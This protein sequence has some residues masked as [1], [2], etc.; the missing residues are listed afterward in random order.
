MRHDHAR[1][2][3]EFADLLR[4]LPDAQHAWHDVK[5]LP[6]TV[7]P[8]AN[9]LFDDPVAATRHVGAHGQAV[10]GRRGDH[11]DLAQSQQTH[12]E[13][14]GNGRGRHGEHVDLGLELLESDDISEEEAE[15][16][17]IAT[18]LQNDDVT[19]G[20]VKCLGKVFE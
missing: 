3:D 4:M 19:Q 14:A 8:A 2:G 18:L 11:A 17:A 20:I 7:E 13:G 12:V 9:P 5:D 15:R 1:I 6:A 10:R 16:K